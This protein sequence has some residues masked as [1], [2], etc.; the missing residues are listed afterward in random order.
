MQQNE[1]ELLFSERVK[2]IPK[3]FLR[4]IL[5]VTSQPDI[6][7][8]AG[9]LPNPEFFPVEAIKAASKKVLENDG[10]NVLQY[11]VSEGYYPL[12][13]YIAE[14]YAQKGLEVDPEEI[15][16]TNGSQQA[17]DLVGKI[18]IDPGDHILME[19]PSYLGAIQAF[20]LYQPTFLGVDLLGD[21]IDLNG[22]R[23]VIRD[24]AVKLFYT[25]PN[26]QN[27]TGISC[28]EHKREEMAKIILQS[29][30][31]LVEDDPYGDINFKEES[32]P[33]VKKLIGK[34]GILLG[35]FSKIISP[36]MRLGWVVAEKRIIE[37]LLL[38]KQ[39]SDLHSNFLSQRIIYQYLLDNDLDRHITT[40]KEAYRKQKNFMIEMIEKHFPKQIN[41]NDPEGGMFVWLKLPAKI[42]AFQLLECAAKEKV[43]FVP[44]EIFYVDRAEKNTLRLNFSNSTAPQIEKGIEIMGKLLAKAL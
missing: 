17:L 15:L 37:K 1:N 16:I 27:P 14:R 32:V 23:K 38:V 12:R 22:F 4:E 19:R 11:A 30:T 44:G 2:H 9:G 39:A 33:P 36:G 35:S 21:G 20:S 26:F 28:A 25:V 18:F 29:N 31:L 5:K 3:S 7:S 42:N 24:N 41:Y 34:Q 6:I 8:F 13:K 43:V 40:I 10:K